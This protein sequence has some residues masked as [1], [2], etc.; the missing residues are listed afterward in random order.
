MNN[1]RAVLEYLKSDKVKE[2]QEGLSAIRSIFVQDHVVR[3]FHVDREGKGD[4]R[5]WL[6]VFQGLFSTVLTEKTACARKSA[7]KT[8]TNTERRAGDAAKVVRWLTVSVMNKRVAKASF[9]HLTQDIKTRF[10]VM[11]IIEAN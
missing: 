9:E 8:T 7:S 3:T 5:V 4:P 1:L 10:Q 6:S 2:R 11:T